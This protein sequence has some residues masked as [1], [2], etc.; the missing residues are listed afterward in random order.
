[1]KIP[2]LENTSKGS[3]WGQRATV[4]AA[5]SVKDLRSGESGSM[6][7]GASSGISTHFLVY[8]GLQL[9]SETK[10]RKCDVWQHGN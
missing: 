2:F 9:L 4:D 3:K 10:L 8:A 7:L 5:E 6:R 1:M